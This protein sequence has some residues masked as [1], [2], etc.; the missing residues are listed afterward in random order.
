MFM[1]NHG[2]KHS[3]PKSIHPNERD[4]RTPD[5]ARMNKRMGQVA[6]AKESSQLKPRY[7]TVKNWK[8]FGA[9]HEPSLG[10]AR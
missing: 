9:F 3:E 6:I 5:L 1:R 8:G 4:D 10:S 7:G 2:L